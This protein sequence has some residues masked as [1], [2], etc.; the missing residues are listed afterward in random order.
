MPQSIGLICFILKDRGHL[1]SWNNPKGLSRKLLRLMRIFFKAGEE[2][3]TL[4]LSGQVTRIDVAN[5]FV[6]EGFVC[7][8][9]L[10]LISLL[11]MHF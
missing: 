7:R 9:G 11:L 6:S 3:K 10:T 5:R 8:G 2:K 4:W 1:Y